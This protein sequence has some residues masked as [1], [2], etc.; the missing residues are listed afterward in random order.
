MIKVQDHNV[1]ISGNM[2]ELLAEVTQVT[3]RLYIHM[4]KADGVEFADAMLDQI[5]ELAK[6]TDKEISKKAIRILSGEE[7]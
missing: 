3:R 4:V 6:L 5:I 2:P 1:E 7:S